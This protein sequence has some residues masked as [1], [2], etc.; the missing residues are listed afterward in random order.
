M[1]AVVLKTGKECET[2]QCC[3]VITKPITQLVGT[4]QQGHSF[5][6]CVGLWHGLQQ[7][8]QCLTFHVRP[9]TGAIDSNLPQYHGESSRRNDKGSFSITGW[10]QCFLCVQCVTMSCCSKT[11]VFWRN[12]YCQRG[13]QFSEA[14]VDLCAYACACERKGE[15][16]G[17]L[18]MNTGIRD[19]VTGQ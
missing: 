6:S 12:P 2:V 8:I 11:G 4:E 14:A 1:L 7:I 19:Y 9:L 17:T 18:H 5:F 16:C 15:R 3:I 10:Q 13:Q